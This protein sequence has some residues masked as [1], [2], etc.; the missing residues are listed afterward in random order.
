MIIIKILPLY[1]KTMKKKKKKCL[2]FYKINPEKKLL[3]KLHE[4]LKMQRDKQ[5][6]YLKKLKYIQ[7]ITIFLKMK[8]INNKSNNNSNKNNNRKK[9]ESKL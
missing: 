3:R 1:L 9:K 4:F 7:I 5:Q 6:P 8:S 2:N